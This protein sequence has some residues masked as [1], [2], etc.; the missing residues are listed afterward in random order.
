MGAVLSHLPP[1]GSWHHVPLERLHHRAGLLRRPALRPA[2][3]PRVGQQL[4][5]RLR[6]GVPAHQ[7][8]RPVRDGGDPHRE[9]ALAQGNAHHA[10]LRHGRR[11][12]A[13][14]LRHLRE[15]HERRRHDGAHPHHAPRAR[16]AHGG[17]PG[18]QLRPGVRPAPSV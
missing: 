17:G 2:L 11:A 5:E 10:T 9:Q 8:V 6:N 15:A 3:H 18:R 13:D 7:R 1:R 16:R 14:G 12:R 4:R